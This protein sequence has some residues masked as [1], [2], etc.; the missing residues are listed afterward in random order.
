M[1]DFPLK[2]Y[3]LKLVDENLENEKILI[4]EPYFSK[5]FNLVFNDTISTD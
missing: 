2:I 5:Y 4:V 3:Y 1:S